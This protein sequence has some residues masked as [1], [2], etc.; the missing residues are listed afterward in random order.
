MK[1]FRKITKDTILP[2]ILEEQFFW[3][4]DIFIIYNSADTDITKEWPLSWSN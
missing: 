4:P 2:A 3:L 1:D